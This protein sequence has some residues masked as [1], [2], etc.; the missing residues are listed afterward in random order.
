MNLYLTVICT[1]SFIFQP[2]YLSSGSPMASASVA[3]QST[4]QTQ[5]CAGR[6]PITGPLT[7]DHPYSDW[8]HI[9]MPMDLKCTRRTPK[10]TSVEHA[11]STHTVAPAGNQLFF[12]SMLWANDTKWSK[13]FKNMLY[14]IDWMI[15]F[16]F[17]PLPVAVVFASHSH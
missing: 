14:I 4:R 12:S 10:Y 3:V 16:I 2:A 17:L 11:T 9:A 13:L 5:P 1:H 8:D 15:T 6:H 7:P